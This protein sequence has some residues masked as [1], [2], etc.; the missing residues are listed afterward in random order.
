MTQS[1]IYSYTF[2]I[3]VKFQF[4][5]AFENRIFISYESL[6]ECHDMID[7]YEKKLT[8]EGRNLLYT[9]IVHTETNKHL[10]FDYCD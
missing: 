6:S 4:Q 9:E 3:G 10:D 1:N 7:K 5:D 8:V 2:K